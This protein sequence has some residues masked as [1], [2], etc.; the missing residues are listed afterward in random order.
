MDASHEPIFICGNDRSGT[1]MLR[2]I[3][4]RGAI[5]IPTPSFFLM[6]FEAV[7]HG[8]R[9]L[10]D[11]AE[12]EAFMAEV[13]DHPKVRL[14]NLEAQPPV[15]PVGLSQDNAYRFAVGSVFEAFAEQA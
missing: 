2:L 14:W 5:A 7:H 3:M 11:P 4:G 15:T 6:D 8:S 1:T 12:L 13:W 9:D 10:T